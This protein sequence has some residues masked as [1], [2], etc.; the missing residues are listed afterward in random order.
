MRPSSGYSS[1]ITFHLN[2]F[3]SFKNIFIYSLNFYI[4]IPCILITQA[5]PPPISPE[6]PNT[7]SSLFPILFVFCILAPRQCYSF[8]RECRT[9]HRGMSKLPV[10]IVAMKIVLTHLLAIDSHQLLRQVC[11]L[12][13]ASS[14]HTEI[15]TGLTLCRSC[16]G[17]HSFWRL[18]FNGLCYFLLVFS[19]QVLFIILPW[20]LF[21][22]RE[23]KHHEIND[24]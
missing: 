22:F 10:P 2:Q 5:M 6:A 3:S 15:F 23:E 11:G 19:I 8:E 18:F 9:I 21:A 12:G 20:L 24:S 4:S 13:E 14:V 17:N 7:S 16:S 1:C